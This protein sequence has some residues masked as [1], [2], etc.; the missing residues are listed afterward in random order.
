M[1]ANLSPGCFLE[2]RVGWRVDWRALILVVI[3][4]T[5]FDAFLDVKS[6]MSTQASPDLP[7]GFGKIH[8]VYCQVVSLAL[9]HDCCSPRSDFA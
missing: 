4:A 9:L 5:F 7:L 8:S 1:A 3:F 6:A 2:V